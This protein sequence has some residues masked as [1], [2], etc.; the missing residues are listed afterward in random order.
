M[1]ITHADLNGLTEKE[2]DKFNELV[3]DMLAEDRLLSWF[4]AI[5]KAY[6]TIISQRRSGL[7]G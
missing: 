2:Y 1:A 6:E 7:K 5:Q 4:D 3:Q